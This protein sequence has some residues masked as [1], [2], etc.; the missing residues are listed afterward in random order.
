MLGLMRLT[1]DAAKPASYAPVM[2][3]A[4]FPTKMFYTF[5]NVLSMMHIGV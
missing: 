5:S 3:I 1:Y 4:S 2:F